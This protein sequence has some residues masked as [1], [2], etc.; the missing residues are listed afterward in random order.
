[1]KRVPPMWSLSKDETIT[2]FEAWKGNFLYT[3]NL[4]DNFSQFLNGQ[5][6][7]KKIKG[8]AP[9]RGLQNSQQ[10]NFLNLMLGQISNYVPVISRNTILQ[11][12]SSIESIWHVIKSHYGFQS[13]GSSFLN[14]CDIK[15]EPGE[16]H[17]D[18]FQRIQSFFENNLLSPDCGILHHGDKITEDEDLS[19]TL[20]NVIVYLWLQLIHKDLPG[21]IKIKYGPE[22]RHKSLASIKPEISGALNSLL[23][24]LGA[25]HPSIL[26][27]SGSS[28]N[29]YQNQGF[30]P[31]TRPN[32]Y[33]T[34]SRP[35]QFGQRPSFRQNYQPPR[36][37]STSRSPVFSICKNAG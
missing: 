18:L 35:G 28:Y 8:G 15:L 23:E 24:E 19:P 16:R 7:D 29:N 26:R 14:L 5:T 22:L 9:Y 21:L 10:E 11:N 27:A 33:L 34:N 17:E 31:R 4:D 37:Q 20:E 36:N 2:S 25:S 3:L 12:S 1:M 32:Q 13:S 30:N 6:W